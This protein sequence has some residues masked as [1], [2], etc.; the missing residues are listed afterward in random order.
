MVLL[1]GLCV[2]LCYINVFLTFECAHLLDYTFSSVVGALGVPATNGSAPSQQAFI[3][4]AAT[5]LPTSILPAQVISMAPEPIGIP[6]ECL[7]LKNM[8]D[9][10]TEVSVLLLFVFFFFAVGEP[11]FPPCLYIS[12]F[13]LQ[14]DPEFDLDIKDDVQEECSK[15]GRVKHIFVDK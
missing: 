14:A 4:N 1:Q 15:Y 2:E 3:T 5:L 6:S 13:F 11:L 9:P 8:F 7:L 10:A 12:I